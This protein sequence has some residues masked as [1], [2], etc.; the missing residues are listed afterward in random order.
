MHLSTDKS[1]LLIKVR[2][3]LI[4]LQSFKFP[5]GKLI[6]DVVKMSY[7]IFP[8]IKGLILHGGNI[9]NEKNN[10]YI[11]LVID[12][13]KPSNITKSNKNINLD[14]SISKHDLEFFNNLKDEM[15]HI[16]S[17]LIDKS[18]L[19]KKLLKV[20]ETTRPIEIFHPFS[21]TTK[22][23]FQKSDYIWTSTGNLQK[24]GSLSPTI[25][26]HLLSIKEYENARKNM[27]NN[28]N[29]K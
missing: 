13:P 10:S 7:Q 16:I 23:Y 24:L 8:I 6:Y 28:I 20:S 29:K 21:N 17:S 5:P 12:K 26:S 14:W 18:T 4:C 3:L 19:P 1:D 2:E 9:S 15:L 11:H 27:C 25:A 22:K